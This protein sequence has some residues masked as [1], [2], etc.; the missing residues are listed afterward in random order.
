MMA[1][2]TDRAASEVRCETASLL[3]G[4]E[5]VCVKVYR[6]CVYEGC[7]YEGC[8]YEFNRIENSPDQNKNKL[9]L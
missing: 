3:T 5:V 2:V 4:K 9:V 8:V 7:V 1:I 6:N